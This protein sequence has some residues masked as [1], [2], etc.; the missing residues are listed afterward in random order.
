MKLFCFLVHLWGWAWPVWPNA[1]F[2]AWDFFG[3]NRVPYQVIP[4]EKAQDIN[5]P[6]IFARLTGL[7]YQIKLFKIILVRLRCIL[8]GFPNLHTTFHIRSS[9]GMLSTPL[10][11]SSVLGLIPLR[12]SEKVLVSKPPIPPHPG[13]HHPQYNNQL[14][15]FYTFFC[16]K[17]GLNCL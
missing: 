12:L 1:N 8:I 13:H 10:T 15:Q 7:Y 3:D 11:N 16:S 5:F 14:F 4:N 17:F 6:D 9:C 2:P